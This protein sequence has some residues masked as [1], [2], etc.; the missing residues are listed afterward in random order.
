MN[1]AILLYKCFR[2]ILAK[3][4]GLLI[5]LLPFSRRCLV[6][7]S[8]AV[9]LWKINCRNHTLICSKISLV[10]DTGLKLK[11]E[12]N[13]RVLPCVFA[14]VRQGVCQ[15]FLVVGGIGSVDKR[16]K[17]GRDQEAADTRE[18]DLRLVDPAVE[19]IVERR[20]WKTYFRLFP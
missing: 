16:P 6:R 13:C 19:E 7:S 11:V 20:P 2:L 4:F 14:V 3:W 17:D 10:V 5:Q 18:E 8:S 9:F 15:F 1:N 12:G